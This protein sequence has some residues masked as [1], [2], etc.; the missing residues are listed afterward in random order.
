MSSGSRTII[1]KTHFVHILF[2]FR[3]LSE[4]ALPQGS[5]VKGALTVEKIFLSIFWVLLHAGLASQA[6]ENCLRAVRHGP[7]FV[8]STKPQFSGVA[9]FRGSGRYAATANRGTTCEK[10]R[11]PACGK[12]RPRRMAGK[13]FFRRTDSIRTPGLMPLPFPRF[14]EKNRVKL[15]ILPTFLL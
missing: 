9:A 4:G 12:C 7:H 11:F 6:L 15:L 5:P 13:R 2:V 10:A 8:Q 1:R 14:F 3:I